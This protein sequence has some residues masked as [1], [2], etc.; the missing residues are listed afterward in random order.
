HRLLGHH[1]TLT[2]IGDLDAQLAEVLEDAPVELALHT[3]A[4]LVDTTHLPGQRHH[5]AVHRVDAPDG[6]IVDDQVGERRIRTQFR[7][8]LLQFGD[9]LVDVGVVA[10]T[11]PHRRVAD[12]AV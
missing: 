11:D 3:P 6:Q 10:D 2:R 5:R 1:E 9:R 8:D 4:A 12:A 7:A